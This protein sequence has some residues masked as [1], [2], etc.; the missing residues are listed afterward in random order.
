[1]SAHTPGCVWDENRRCYTTIAPGC[2][3]PEEHA[4][5]T[6]PTFCPACGGEI[7]YRDE[8]HRCP[9]VKP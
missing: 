3:A 4:K 1:M 9:E 8:P 5:W 6:H 2:A 7:V